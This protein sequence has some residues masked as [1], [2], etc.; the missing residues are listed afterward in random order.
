MCLRRDRGP[1]TK[2]I[3]AED[4]WR[5]PPARRTPSWHRRHNEIRRANPYAV[6]A[7]YRLQQYALE[8]AVGAS[9]ERAIR[10]AA[11]SRALPTGLI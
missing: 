3:K 4:D 11:A 7:G 5:V 8:A 6:A 1:E 10:F 9:R 2:S